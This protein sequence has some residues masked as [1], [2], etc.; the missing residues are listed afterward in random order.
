MLIVPPK[1]RLDLARYQHRTLYFLA[2]PVRGGGDWQYTMVNFISR[3]DPDAIVVVPTRWDNTHPLRTQF[4][5]EDDGYFE[6]QLDFERS[7]MELAAWDHPQGCLAFWLGKQREPRAPEDGPY[8][9]DTYGEFARWAVH[10]KYRPETRMV[11]GA[12][13]G[14]PGLDVMVRNLR[15]DVGYE[16]PIHDS[17]ES[18]AWAAA[19]MSVKTP[20]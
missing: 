17:M 4:A 3:Y 9:Q 15:K 18:T 1:R 5:G 20:A 12:E 7:H 13:P 10:S 16:F 2:G 8:G 14:Y 11:V 6:R 19:R